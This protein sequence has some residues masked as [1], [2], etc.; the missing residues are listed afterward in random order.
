MW[1]KQVAVIDSSTRPAKI[2]GYPSHNNPGVAGL[3]SLTEETQ[4]DQP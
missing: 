3:K 2:H 4:L 1:M